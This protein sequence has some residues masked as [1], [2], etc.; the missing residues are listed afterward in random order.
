MLRQPAQNVIITNYSCY[1]NLAKALL[2]TIPKDWML[3][4]V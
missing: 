3:R 1:D 4:F 2:P